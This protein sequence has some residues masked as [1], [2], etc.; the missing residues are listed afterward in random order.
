[1]YLINFSENISRL[2]REK[3]ITQE[4]LADFVGV[5]KASVSKWETGQ[6]IPDVMILPQLANF[7]D[8]TIDEILGYQPQLSNEQMKKIY[9]D[10]CSEFATNEFENVME[11]SSN[12]VKKYYSCYPF[13]YRLSLLWINHYMLTM[14]LERQKEILTDALN[15]C[16]R[17]IEN[18]KDIALCNDAV[19]LK[20]TIKLLLGDAQDVID[21]L[22][23][24]MNPCRIG[25]Q[26]AGILIKAYQ[27]VNKLDKANEYTQITMYT[28][29]IEIVGCA[30]E[31][32]TIHSNDLSVCEETIRRVEMIANAYDLGHLNPSTISVFYYQVAIVYCMQGMKDKGLL[33][34]EKFVNCIEEFFKDGNVGL[35]SDEYFNKLDVWFEQMELGGNVPRD[36]KVILESAIQGLN[37]PVFAI[38]E[39]ELKYQKMKKR[40][41][42]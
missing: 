39:D 7:F 17:I 6:S 2:R 20:A 32:I 23:E 37:H 31:Y 28:K 5:T 26:S 21:S 14:D 24:I 40:L 13:L 3:K 10:L 30:V 8:V 22:E 35:R 27:M 11:K 29:I 16:I 25:S 33:Y 34:L 38:L 18:S 12:L 19:H 36:K 4:Q 15:L 9:L 1:M 42:V 41:I